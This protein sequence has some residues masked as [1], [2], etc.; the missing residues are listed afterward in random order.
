MGLKTKTSR[1]SVKF[2]EKE[3]EN[4]NSW[5]DFELI[6]AKKEKNQLLLWDKNNFDST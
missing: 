5:D 1:E 2:V 4:P 3:L 6:E